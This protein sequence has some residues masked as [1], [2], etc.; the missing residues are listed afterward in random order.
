MN[1]GIDIS[2]IAHEGTGVAT[3]VRSLVA[4]LIA[5]DKKNQYILFGAS[6]RKQQVF[7][8]FVEELGNP[9]HVRLVVVPIPPKVLTILWNRLHILPIER[10]IGSVDVFWSSDWT[11]P[12]LAKACGITTIH[13]VS[14]LRYPQSFVSEISDEHKRRLAWAK[15]ECDV[16]LCD[17]EATKADVQTYLG[18]PA[19]KLFVVYPGFRPII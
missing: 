15:R 19:N 9:A 14:F 7:R 3:Y 2:Q 16:F 5:Q 17:S 8:S 11:Q 12:P 1:I 6:F 10:F 13:D 4:S 18:L